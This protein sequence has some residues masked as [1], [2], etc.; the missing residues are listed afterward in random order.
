MP[1]FPWQCHFTHQ[2]QFP[3]VV[4]EYTLLTGRAAIL[5]DIFSPS[6]E[7]IFVRQKSIKKY[8]TDYRLASH[9]FRHRTHFSRLTGKNEF[10]D[11]EKYNYSITYNT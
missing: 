2:Q 1:S 9:A 6:R 10:N 3:D 11:Y 7:G 4:S 8:Q 5:Q